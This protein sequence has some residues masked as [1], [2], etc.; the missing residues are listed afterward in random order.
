M[1]R[2]PGVGASAAARCLARPGLPPVPEK[3]MAV[4]EIAGRVPVTDGSG[5]ELN[6][7]LQCREREGEV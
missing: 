7:F 5:S 4:A 6:W 1:R 3:D 2:R